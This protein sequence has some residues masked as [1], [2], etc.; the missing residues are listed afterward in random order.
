[1]C[2]RVAPCN[3][4]DD[5]ANPNALNSYLLADSGGGKD[6]NIGASG[7]LGKVPKKLCGTADLAVRL[8]DWLALLIRRNIGR[9]SLS[10]TIKSTILRI[11]AA[12]SALGMHHNTGCEQ[13]AAAE[14]RSAFAELPWETSKMTG[15]EVGLCTRRIAPPSACAPFI[16]SLMSSKSS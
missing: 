8:E 4:Y 15:Q 2:S 1:M 10:R 16:K 3:G 9:I 6:L 14:A 11:A 13:L 12:R 5:L 7:R